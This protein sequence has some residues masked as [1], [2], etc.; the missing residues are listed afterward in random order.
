MAVAVCKGR[1][2]IRESRYYVIR[3]VMAGLYG[4]GICAADTDWSSP[5]H[6]DD[7]RIRIK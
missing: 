5:G 4:C 6:A 3:D 7:G 1:R 2:F